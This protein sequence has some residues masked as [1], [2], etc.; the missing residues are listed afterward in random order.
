MLLKLSADILDRLDIF[1][2]EIEE[3]RVPKPLLWEYVWCIS[4]ILTF[5][6]LSS[7]RKNK[8][9][10]MQKYM[11]GVL[12]FGY[13]PIIYCFA[14]YFGDVMEYMHLEEDQDIEDTEIFMW[15]VSNLR[16]I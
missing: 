8:V 11:I 7:A 3:L 6:G 10:D 13:L 14:Y 12:V 2:L 5:M 1:I 16:F 15:L 9:R 4:V